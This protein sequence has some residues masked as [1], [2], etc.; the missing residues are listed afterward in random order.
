MLDRQKVI[1]EPYR[2]TMLEELAP[3]I[4]DERWDNVPAVATYRHLMYALL[5]KDPSH[6][7]ECFT[8]LLDAHAAHFPPEEMR[9]LSYFAINYCIHQIRLGETAYTEDLMKLYEQGLSRGYLLEEGK[10]SPWTFKNMVKLGLGLQRF[11]WVETF[12]A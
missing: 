9:D 7:F 4:D 1:P 6:N 11:D 3:V 2:L 12:V 8:H 5:N 10:L